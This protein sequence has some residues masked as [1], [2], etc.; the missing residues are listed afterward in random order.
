MNVVDNIAPRIAEE[1]RHRPSQGGDERHDDESLPGW[2][3]RARNPGRSSTVSTQAV[4]GVPS[5]AMTTDAIIATLEIIVAAGV[6][7]EVIV[8]W[9]VIGLSNWLSF[10]VPFWALGLIFAGPIALALAT[11][12][13]VWL[14][15]MRR[16]RT[17]NR[18][19][20]RHDRDGGGGVH[21]A[22]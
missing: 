16:N 22:A 12:L 4:N 11:A 3:G 14:V 2:I 5:A 10:D 6:F 9:A 8:P 20:A 13:I 19:N 1:L 18:L 7:G 15:L 17:D 21:H